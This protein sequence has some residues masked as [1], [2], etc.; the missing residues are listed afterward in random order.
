MVGERIRLVPAITIM[1]CLEKVPY[2][3][4]QLAAAQELHPRYALHPRPRAT[5]CQTLPPTDCPGSFDFFPPHLSF[6]TNDSSGMWSI[7]IKRRAP[8]EP[9]PSTEPVLIL[10]PP[11]PSNRF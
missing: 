1:R 6:P 4:P 10:A 9:H 5:R 3:A 8:Q 2:L 11:P 7:R